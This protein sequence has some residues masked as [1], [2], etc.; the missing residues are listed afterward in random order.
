LFLLNDLGK[1]EA[2]FCRGEKIR[3]HVTNE[4]LALTTGSPIINYHVL[5]T[6]YAPDRQ[7]KIEEGQP[8]ER[9]QRE[10]A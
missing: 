7:V 4:A 6:L 5:V 1:E 10:Y 8:V 2:V 3:K 9:L